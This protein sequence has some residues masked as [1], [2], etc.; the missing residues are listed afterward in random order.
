MVKIKL[1]Y[2]KIADSK[3]YPVEKCVAFEKYDGT[4]LHWVWEDE[5]G[6]YGFGTRRD[7]FDFDRMGIAE[8]NAAHPGLED[9]PQL[10]LRD[11]AQPL[12]QIFRENPLYHSPEITVFTE[13]FGINSFAGMHKPEDIKQL[14]LFDVQIYTNIIH[15]EQFVQDFGKL[16]IA[17]VVYRGKLTS[18]FVD[19]VRQGKYGVGEGVVCKGGK[20]QASLWMVKIK[21]D[22]YMKKLQQVFKDDWQKYWE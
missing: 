22:G 15:P 12:E 21:T 16:K 19:E 6:W 1:A 20:N 11:F 2:P 8:F 3:N 4:N 10:F 14:I 5:L 9:A 17:R 7:R 13:F 18:K